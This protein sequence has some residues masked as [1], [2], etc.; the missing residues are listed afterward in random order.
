MR[1]F[2][3]RRIG[4]QFQIVDV[5]VCVYCTMYI[6]NVNYNFYTMYRICCLNAWWYG[7]V[8]GVFS[9]KMRHLIKQEYESLNVSYYAKHVVSMFWEFCDAFS[10]DGFILWARCTSKHI[11]YTWISYCSTLP[12]ASP[13][14]Y[15]NDR[16]WHVQ[17]FAFLLCSYIKFMTDKPGAKER[18]GEWIR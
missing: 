15:I 1:I 10:I 17:M 3:I 4:F 7:V 18:A 6:S 12:M 11:Y 14:N 8:C 16:S 13:Q 9:W 2:E 5:C